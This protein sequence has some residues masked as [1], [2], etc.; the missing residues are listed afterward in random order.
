MGSKTQ[1]TSAPKETRVLPTVNALAHL[2]KQENGRGEAMGLAEVLLKHQG[3]MLMS[4]ESEDVEASGMLR[5]GGTQ[6]TS[7]FFEIL[8]INQDHTIWGDNEQSPPV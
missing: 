6:L 4:L 7:P 5:V 2:R 3:N 1:E 8:R